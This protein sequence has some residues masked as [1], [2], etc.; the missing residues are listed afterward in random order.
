MPWRTFTP[1]SSSA[2]TLFF[3]AATLAAWGCASSADGGGEATGPQGFS[4]QVNHDPGAGAGADGAAPAGPNCGNGVVDPGEQCD[5]TDLQGQTCASATLSARPDGQLACVNCALDASGCSSGAG[6]PGGGTGGGVGTG[7]GGTTGG[8]AQPGNGGDG[9]AATGSG[10]T[11]G[12][13]T[14]GTTAGGT[15]CS[16]G[17]CLCH[18]P[19]PPSL[20]TSPGTFTTGT[21]TNTLGTIHYPTNADPPFAGVALC[22]GFL[23]TGPEMDGWGSFYASYGIVTIITTTLGS[24]DPNIRATKL[25]AAIGALKQENTTSSSPL[26]GKMAGRYGTS[27]YSMGGGGTTIASSQ[28]STLRTSVGLAPWGP[29]GNGVSVPTLLLCGDADTVAPCTMAQGAYGAMTGPKMMMTIPGATHFNWFG[30]KDAGGG[31]SGETALAF[32]KVYL[33]GDERWKPLLLAGRGTVTTTIH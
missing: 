27:G 22:G 14:G 5:G 19:V 6:G 2:L 3:G 11:L 33:E 4:G 8:G 9:G 25:L 15:C 12:G 16:G 23:N 29:T 13:G 1:I 26:F 31:M 28:D 21:I 17:D 18:G 20:T 24:D 7:T 30:P 32:E 10:G